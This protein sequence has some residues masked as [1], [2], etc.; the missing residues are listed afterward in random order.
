[1]IACFAVGTLISRSSWVLYASLFG[2]C[3]A[4][5]FLLGT[6]LHWSV[7]DATANVIETA[8]LVGL[9]VYWLGIALYARK[10][11][12]TRWVWALP[13]VLSIDNITY[14]LIDHAWSHSVAVQA[15]EQLVSSAL[16]AGIGLL[17]SAAV[18]RAIPG[19]KRRSATFAAGFAGAALIVA[20]PVLLAVG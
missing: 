4:G 6:W 14:G 18:M 11:A 12:E 2:I 3:D 16:L 7:P 5:G 15:L 17:A 13:V 19:T 20:A 9:G 8:V 1:M 10:I